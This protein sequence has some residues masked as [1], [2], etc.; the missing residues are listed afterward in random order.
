MVKLRAAKSN[1]VK[2]HKQSMHCMMSMCLLAHCEQSN[3][4]KSHKQSMHCMIPMCL[5][6][7]CGQIH[8]AEVSQTINAM[9]DVCK[10]LASSNVAAALT[11]ADSLSA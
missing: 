1:L 9:Q 8:M 6:A 11:F 10:Q 3:M 5:M 7:Q 4:M 2:S